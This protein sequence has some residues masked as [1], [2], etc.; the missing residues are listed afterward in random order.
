VN[1][2]LSNPKPGFWP[3]SWGFPIG[4][5]G[6]W[7]KVGQTGAY[8]IPVLADG[9]WFHGLPLQVD[10]PSRYSDQVDNP[11]FNMQRY[12]IDR[13]RGAI[14][15]AFMDWS[16]RKVGLKYLWEL[17]W[18]RSFDTSASKPVWPN[19]MARY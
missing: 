13:H 19:W 2:W 12:C 14:N 18:H 17:K 4:E 9:V 16:V 10:R 7:R 8:N 15:V 11:N 3:S 5:N 1:G 6:L